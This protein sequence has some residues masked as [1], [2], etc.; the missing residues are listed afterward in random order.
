M[1]G[2]ALR[3]APGRRTRSCA[4]FALACGHWP[5]TACRCWATCLVPAGVYLMTGHGP[6]GLPVGPYSAMLVAGMMMGQTSED[7]LS[8]FHLSRFLNA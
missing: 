6:T 4:R 2:E 8:A 5:P 7:D 1:L 3:V